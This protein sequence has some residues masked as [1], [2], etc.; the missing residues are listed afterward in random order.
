M[1]EV[2]SVTEKITPRFKTKYR[3]EIRAALQEQFGYDN[4]M[5]IPG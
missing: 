4:V 2:Q 5:E 1:T 3:E